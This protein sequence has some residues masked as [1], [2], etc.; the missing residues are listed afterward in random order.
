MTINGSG[1]RPPLQ[2]KPT[3]YRRNSSKFDAPINGEGPFSP[4]DFWTAKSSL[5]QSVQLVKNLLVGILLR[6]ISEMLAPFAFADAVFGHEVQPIT[7]HH[8]VRRFCT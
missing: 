2:F 8:T 3:H 6:P 5:L 7:K 4:V 1:H